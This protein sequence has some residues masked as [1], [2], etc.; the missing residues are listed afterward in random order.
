MASLLQ[1]LLKS[2]AGLLRLLQLAFRR[3]VD[4]GT[5]GRADI[6]ALSHALRRIVLLKKYL[7]EARERDH[8]RIVDNLDHFRV[9]RL[10]CRR[11]LIGGIA[12]ETTSITHRR[13]PH[14][15]R[16]PEQPFRAPEAAHAEIDGFKAV[17]IRSLQ[18]PAIDKMGFRHRKRRFTARQG[19][20]LRRHRRL[21]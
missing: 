20:F 12:G 9:A 11:L 2:I 1:S 6:V 7:Q 8:G 17:G 3:R 4:G 10:T 21:F 14:P 5:I 16:F 19:G 18:R 13:H 15:R